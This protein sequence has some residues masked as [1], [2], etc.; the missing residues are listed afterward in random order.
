VLD[1]WGVNEGSLWPEI[2][3]KVRVGLL[4][5]VEQSVDEVL[6]SS[7]LTGGLGVNIIDTGEGE[8]L[9]GDLGGNTSG[10][11]WGWDESDA[12]GTA[13]T[14]DLGWDGMD[15]TDLGTPVTSSDWDK[16]ALGVDEGTLN[17]D[18]DFLS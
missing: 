2:W 13:L 17:G 5:G 1:E 3:G 11:S 10:T 18:L 15:T 9:L 16:V 12:G 8:D 14:V 4:K 7:G 6:S